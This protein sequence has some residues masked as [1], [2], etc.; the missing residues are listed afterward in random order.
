MTDW[1]VTAGIRGQVA[2]LL[3]SWSAFACFSVS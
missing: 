1:G 3:A 2:L